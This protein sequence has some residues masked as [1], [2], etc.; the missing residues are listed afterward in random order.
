MALDVLAARL[1]TLLDVGSLPASQ[2]TGKM[3]ARLDPLFRVGALVEEHQG[4]GKRVDL[5][6]RE[7]LE[8][9]IGSNYPSGLLGTDAA[10]PARA[11]SA[12]NF[13]NTKRGRALEVALVHMRGFG[14]CRLKRGPCEQPLAALT[15]AFGVAGVLIDPAQPWQLSGTLGIVENLELFMQ[16]ERVVP[17]LDAAL[18]AAGRLANHVLSW[19][20]KQDQLQV[21][22]FGDY[23]PVG[24]SEYLRLRATLGQRVQL[25]VP[26]DFEERLSRFGQR[27]LLIRSADL[28][29]GVRRRADES[30]RQVLAIIERHGLGLE[31]ESIVIPL[32]GSNCETMLGRSAVSDESEGSCQ[33]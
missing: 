14:Q 29:P 32:S 17:A 31:H 18:W 3:R 19:L 4:R 23:D 22:H 21:I 20:G 27:E 5:K 2:L 33:F 1:Q 10:L 7:S 6:H 11:E 15:A 8:R 24:L 26:P 30:V 13:R 12:A 9:W 28:F 16:I 25:Y